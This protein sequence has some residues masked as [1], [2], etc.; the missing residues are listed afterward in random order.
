MERSGLKHKSKNEK[1]LTR[2]NFK[3]YHDNLSQPYQR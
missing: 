2:I 1:K 3:H